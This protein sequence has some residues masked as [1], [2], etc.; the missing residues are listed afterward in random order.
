MTKKCKFVFKVYKYMAWLLALFFGELHKQ[1]LPPAPVAFA[2]PM[3]PGVAAALGFK[4]DMDKT[5]MPART[6]TILGV[7]P[8]ER[9][10]G[11]FSRGKGPEG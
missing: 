6:Q 9:S 2:W 5:P 10:S 4:L 7:V 3:Y 11:T 1:P 8:T